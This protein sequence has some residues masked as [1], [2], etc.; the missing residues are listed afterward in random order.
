MIEYAALISGYAALALL[1]ALLYALA[2]FV[3]GRRLGANQGVSA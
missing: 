2:F 1:V 3:H